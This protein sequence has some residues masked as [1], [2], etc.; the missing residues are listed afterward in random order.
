MTSSSTS[1]A[2]RRGC[3]Q[4]PVGEDGVFRSVA[5]VLV[6]VDLAATALA[7]GLRHRLPARPQWTRLWSRYSRCAGAGG[8]EGMAQVGM[9]LAE[10]LG[11]AF[12]QVAASVFEREQGAL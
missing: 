8:G 12:P 11:R 2:E 5:A 4:R 1:G 7:R 9:N 10:N 3:S 6:A